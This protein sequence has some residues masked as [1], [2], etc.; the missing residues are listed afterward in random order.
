MKTYKPQIRTKNF[1]SAPLRNSLGEFPVRTIVR[2]GSRTTVEEAYPKMP[3]GRPVIEINTVNAIE[4]SR[5]KLLM[6]A[7]FAEA[8]VPQANWFIEDSVELF[9]NKQDADH[10][11]N[12]SELPY[13]VLI[14]RVFGF[15][16]HGMIKI[17][18]KE[19]LE[20]WLQNNPNTTNWYIEHYRGFAREYRLHCTQNECFMAWRKLRKAD[21]ENR[22]FFNSTNCN[23]V[24]EEHPLFDKPSNWD[25]IAEAC[26]NATKAVGLDVA[27]VDVRVQSNN[28]ANPEFI[29]LETNSGPA[30]GDQGIEIYRQKLVELINKKIMEFHE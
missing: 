11:I 3:V 28:K 26:V 13:P 9:I 29:V 27:A 15:K 4:N 5:S 8:E 12:T 2:L 21:A 17:D 14:K 18:S 10:L 20:E 22:W 24:S 6:K 7:C 16:G 19:Q 25:T 23:W 1:S 30:L